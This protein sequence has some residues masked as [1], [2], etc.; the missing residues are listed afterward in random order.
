VANQYRERLVELYGAER[1]R[2]L[3]YAEAFELSEYG[4][5]LP[6][7]ELERLFPVAP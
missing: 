4:G 5:Q 1:G 2:Q 7:D 6:P 3:R